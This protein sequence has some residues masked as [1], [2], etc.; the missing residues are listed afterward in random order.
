MELTVENKAYID[1]LSYSGLLSYWRFAL[2]GDR[3]F[4]GATGEYWER[5]MEELRWE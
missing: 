1:R 5:R 4:K 2:R 3:W